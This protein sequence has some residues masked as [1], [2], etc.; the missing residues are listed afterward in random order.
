MS[1]RKLVVGVGNVLMKDD[2]VGVR[3][4]EY[5]RERGVGNDIK[6][7]D[8]ATLGFDILDEIN[9]FEKVVIIDAVDLGK[10]PGHIVS[11][12]AENLISQASGKKFSLHEVTLVD[13][14]QVAKRIGYEFKNVRVVGVQPAD[15]SWGD[16]LSGVL[17][18]KLPDLAERVLKEINN[19]REG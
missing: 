8:G 19:Q 15:V 9:G 10:E 16:K 14:M 3:C 2:G 5:L 11:F 4:V 6:L 1:K 18:E 7:L 13:V 17:S 12:D